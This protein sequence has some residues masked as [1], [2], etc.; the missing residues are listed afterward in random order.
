MS[1]GYDQITAFHYS[2]YRPP[3][4]SPILKEYFGV[5]G[6]HSLGL[7]IGSGTGHS[8]IALAIYCEKVIGIEP[9]E[10]MLSKSLP[11]PRVEYALYDQKHLDFDPN[12]FDIISFA[13]SLYYAKSQQLLHE[14]VRVS[15]HNSQVMVYD[16]EL[17]LDDVLSMLN[18]D[19]TSK[20]KSEYNHQEKFYGLN[21]EGIKIEKEI[22]RPL[23]VEMSISNLAH[24][25]LSSKVNYYPLLEAFGYDNLYNKVAQKLYSVLKAEKTTIEAMTYLTI[26][27]VIK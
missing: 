10:E 21:Q 18:V 3:L 23:T 5:H 24:L 11:H 19:S 1:K 13:G 4:H 6:K 20:Q 17:F 12:S 22:K 26:Y 2:A 14:I 15:K 9:S 8:S 25:L 27:E 7:D 16:F